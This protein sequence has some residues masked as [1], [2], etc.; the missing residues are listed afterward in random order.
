MQRWRKGLGSS[1]SLCMVVY[2]NEMSVKLVG[3]LMCLCHDVKSLS[4]PIILV[5][6]LSIFCNF[7]RHPSA[8]SSTNL[9]RASNFEGK[10]SSPK[11][12]RK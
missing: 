12:T 1:N 9:A 2:L 11:P 5:I 3:Y 7:L 4:E 8:L 10:A 6:Y